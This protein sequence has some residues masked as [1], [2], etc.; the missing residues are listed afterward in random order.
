VRYGTKV[1]LIIKEAQNFVELR[2][3]EVRRILLPRT[4]DEVKH[5][6]TAVV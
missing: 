6:L 4:K 2:K 1:R 3:V 5:R